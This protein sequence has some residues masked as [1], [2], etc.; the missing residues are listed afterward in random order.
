[1]I[2]LVPLRG[3]VRLWMT[4]LLLSYLFAGASLALPSEPRCSWCARTSLSYTVAPGSSCPLS[5]HGHDCHKK[6][7]KTAG[8]ITLCPDGCLHHHGQKGEIP[9]LAKFLS[10]PDSCWLSLFPAVLS[11]DE[12]RLS[13]SDPPFPPPDPPPPV[14]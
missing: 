3:P 7:G 14:C 12:V 9:T 10:A 5:H 11:S 8:Y 2:A 6:T 13:A 1:M 4:F